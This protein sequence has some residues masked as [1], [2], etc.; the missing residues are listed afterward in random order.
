MSAVEKES[1]IQWMQGALQ[2]SPPFSFIFNGLPS[3]QLLQE[4]PAQRATITNEDGTLQH[5]VIYQE[6]TS[7]LECEL[8]LTEYPGSPAVEW[9]VFFRN[10][11]NANTPILEYIQALDLQRDCPATTN[12]TLHFSKG[13]RGAIDDFVLQR[14]DLVIPTE[15]NMLESDDGSS[16]IH[17]PFFNVETGHEG[18]MIGLGWTGDWA[19]SFKRVESG[20]VTVRAGISKT[21]LTLYPGEEIRT[22]RVLLLFWKGDRQKGHN[23][24]RRHLVAH[25]LPKPGGR[26]VEAPIG[27]LSW[28]G[29]KTHNHL[30]LIQF[31]R[32]H[33][34]K[35]DYYWID[36]G[37]FGPDHETDE[38]Q[39]FHTEDWAY[40]VGHWRVNRLVHPDGLKPIADAVHAAG[41]KLLLWCGPYL[42]EENSPLVKE[43]P[44]WMVRLS[45]RGATGIGGNP[46]PV[47]M[48]EVNLGIPECQQHMT[49][50]LLDLIRDNHL[51]CYR[52]DCGIP[53]AVDPPDRVGMS[54]I[55]CVTAFYQIWDE[56]LKQNPDLLID[57]CSG[58][59][60]RVDLETIGR[61]LV[62]WRSD[63]NCSPD[64]DPIGSQ[65]G[66]YGLAHWVPMVG[67]MAP[68]RPGDTYNFRSGWSGGL[69]FGLFHPAGP[70]SAPTAPQPDYPVEWHRTMIAQYRR[71]RPY[72]KGDFY[73]LTNCTLSTQ[74]WLAYQMDRPDLGGGLLIALRRKDSPFLTAQFRLQGLDPA[75]DYELENA[76]TGEK[77]RW[78]G[79]Q[80]A[81]QGI[82]V[83]MTKAPASTLVFYKRVT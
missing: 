61:S 29:M 37:W 23:L 15:I 47:K 68:A 28:G 43:H 33:D 69:P 49:Q 82:T 4:W 55:K 1:A 21:H 46:T 52:D 83:A 51:D 73:P 72:Y 42:A 16:R 27:C 39:N 60:S 7:G 44:E 65:V 50:M 35:F 48:Y 6:P 3:T 66:S 80:L 24:L 22:P 19:C 31:I 10:T 63:Y 41:M 70:G 59:A 26:E 45:Q 20:A 76:D 13:T 64:A 11:G 32:D 79:R 40:N 53:F 12:A 5:T 78:K 8:R 62:L 75:A 81:E 56:L 2:Q 54:Q 77:S 67:G 14:Q 58:G 36:A 34:L 30:K 17:L 25:H 9:V 71:A 74:D 38:F 18:V 57:N